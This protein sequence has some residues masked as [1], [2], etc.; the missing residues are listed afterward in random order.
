MS[1]IAVRSPK[2]TSPKPFDRAVLHLVNTSINR[3]ESNLLQL[4]HGSS[5]R[6]FRFSTFFCAFDPNRRSPLNIVQRPCV[7]HI[8]SR[9]AIVTSTGDCKSKVVLQ[10]RIPPNFIPA[11]RRAQVRSILELRFCVRAKIILVSTDGD[12][13][14]SPLL[15]PQYCA[16]PRKVDQLA[17]AVLV[18]SSTLRRPAATHHRRHHEEHSLNSVC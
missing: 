12:Q 15:P 4:F 7:I 16:L 6:L 11:G 2:E 5:T 17:A 1:T 14:L 13:V 10:T 18:A 3:N 9:P 8:R